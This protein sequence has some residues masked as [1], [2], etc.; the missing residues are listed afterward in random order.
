ML[1]YNIYSHIS[2]N[3]FLEIEKQLIPIQEIMINKLSLYGWKLTNSIKESDALIIDFILDDGSFIGN[4][5]LVYIDKPD[6]AV[7][8]FYV[9]KSY[10][11]LENRYFVKHFISENES[12]IFF[13]Q[14]IC[15]VLDEAIKLYELWDKNYIH[16]NNVNF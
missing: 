16:E 8:S 14:N 11:E 5:G 6:E 4:M 12:L 9:T 10:D 13:E 15:F 3:E 2:N 7:F 1:N